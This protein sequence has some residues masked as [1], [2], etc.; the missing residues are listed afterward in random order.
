MNNEKKGETGKKK[1]DHKTPL[2]LNEQMGDQSIKKGK[3]EDEN[4]ACSQF[5][6]LLI[7]SKSC[8]C[9]EAFAFMKI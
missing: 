3:R 2:G 1:N 6:N 9:F 4:G 5:D 7:H 8:S